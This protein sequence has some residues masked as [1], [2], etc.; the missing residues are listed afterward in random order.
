M[1]KLEFDRYHRFLKNKKNV[2][3]VDS[4]FQDFAK[5]PTIIENS[6]KWLSYEDICARCRGNYKSV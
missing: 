1:R 4:S 6:D 2:H 5:D 3:W